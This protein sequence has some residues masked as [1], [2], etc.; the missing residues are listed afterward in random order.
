MAGEALVTPGSAI[1]HSSSDGCDLKGRFVY[2]GAPPPRKPAVITADREFCG[3][4]NILEENLVV[5]PA[6]RG[7]A[8]VIVWLHLARGESLPPIHRSY[9][10]TEKAEVHL[11]CDGCRFQPHVCLLRTTQTLL[12]RNLNPIGDSA[13]IDTL[14]NPPINIL[15]P[16][17]GQWRQSYPN[18]ERLPARVSCSLHP[19]ESGWFLVNEHPYMAV[20]NADGNF[21]LKALPSGKWVFQFWHEQA[22][23]LTELKSQG[24]ST[25]WK[26]G[27]VELEIKPGENDLGDLLLAPE[28]FAS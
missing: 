18:A 24:K 1:S 27:R 9:A 28:R 13:K 25:A 20:S 14:S 4:Q 2:D 23:Y 10:E 6:N 3:K 26:R 5:N 12:I 8:N 16:M 21:A 19:W 15:V 11:D 7:L 22:G 17:K